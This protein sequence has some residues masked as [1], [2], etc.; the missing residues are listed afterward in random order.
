MQVG[1]NRKAGIDE[2]MGAEDVRVLADI[3][4]MALFG[5]RAE[6]ARSIFDALDVLRPESE[7]A[8]VARANYCLATNDVHKAAE[9]LRAATP[10]DAICALLGLT[11]LKQR[12]GEEA[13]VLLK[14]ASER[15]ADAG[16]TLSA[17]M[18]AE[19]QVMLSGA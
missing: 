14:E 5:D 16:G 2:L 15:Y 12:K 13:L 6:L 3:G 19:I 4:F 7:A 18:L 17:N 10:S 8:V 11:L 1:A 9:I